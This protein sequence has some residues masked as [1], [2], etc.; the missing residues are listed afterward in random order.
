MKNRLLCFAILFSHIIYS[1]DCKKLDS[2]VHDFEEQRLYEKTISKATI[3][4]MKQF[5]RKSAGALVDI[6]YPSE[7]GTSKQLYLTE[8]KQLDELLFNQNYNKVD[9]ETIQSKIKLLKQHEK[10]VVIELGFGKNEKCYEIIKQLTLQYEKFANLITNF[11]DCQFCRLSGSI[12]RGTHCFTNRELSASLKVKNTTNFSIKMFVS[13]ER[14][15]GT[16]TDWESDGYFSTGLKPGMS[17]LW[18][19][20]ESSGNYL[21]L[22]I[23][24][25]DNFNGCKKPK[26]SEFLK[27]ETSELRP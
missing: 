11:P 9:A 21:V 10:G 17:K 14:L 3:F 20:C 2:I 19:T 27:M 6:F 13:F 1:Q 8:V 22:G 26:P 5:L 16:W 4:T 15:D 23:K 25:I 7:L 12:T 18:W 24:V